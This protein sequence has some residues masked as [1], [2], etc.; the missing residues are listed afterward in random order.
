MVNKMNDYSPGIDEI[1]SFYPSA[2]YLKIDGRVEY[3]V[4]ESLNNSIFELVVSLLEMK[5]KP[6]EFFISYHAQ[7]FF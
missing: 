3:V 5:I 1:L 4:M 7:T 6:E 2:E